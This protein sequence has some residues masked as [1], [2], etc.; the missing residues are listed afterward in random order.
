MS[1]LDD[2]LAGLRVAMGDRPYV[3]VLDRRASSSTTQFI[4]V[5]STPNSPTYVV[6]GLLSEA[7]CL[8]DAKYPF[9]VDADDDEDENTDTD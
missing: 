8:V 7:R 3:L 9:V 4:E 5:I 6:R 2:A 1:R